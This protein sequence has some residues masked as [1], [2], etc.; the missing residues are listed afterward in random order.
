MRQR[1]KIRIMKRNKRND[2]VIALGL[3]LSMM[4]SG[5][6]SM[7]NNVNQMGISVEHTYA[8]ETNESMEAGSMKDAF[9]NDVKYPEVP[10][11]DKELEKYLEDNRPDEEEI[12]EIQE[13]SWE[14]AARLI[15]IQGKM[16]T[17][18]QQA[19]ILLYPCLQLA[20]RGKHLKNYMIF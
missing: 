8:H 15:P 3:A 1:E 14:T 4:L 19:Y 16:K 12:E 9:S 10:H 11:N 2:S 20:Q 6:S 5:C 18:H 17:I 7:S 13:F